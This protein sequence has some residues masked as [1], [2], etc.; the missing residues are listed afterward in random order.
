MPLSKEERTNLIFQ[1]HSHQGV[2]LIDRGVKNSLNCFIRVQKIPD[3][4]LNVPLQLYLRVRD[5][6]SL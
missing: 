2:L 4:F 5:K 6:V 1:N 3:V